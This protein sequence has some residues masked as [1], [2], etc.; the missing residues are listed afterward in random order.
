MEFT[1]SCILCR[2]PGSNDRPEHYSFEIL[3][4][5]YA[6]QAST[7]GASLLGLFLVSCTFAQGDPTKSRKL[8]TGK[9]RTAQTSL[10]EYLLVFDAVC[11]YIPGY[12]LSCLASLHWEQ[13]RTTCMHIRNFVP[14]AMRQHVIVHVYSS[15]QLLSMPRQLR[16]RQL[17][18]LIATR[19]LFETHRWR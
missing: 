18:S 6:V 7:V 2:S 10:F 8:L 16:S 15:S 1:R 17:C 19:C 14:G 4:Y 5:A 3:N 9:G 12:K 13:T 11:A